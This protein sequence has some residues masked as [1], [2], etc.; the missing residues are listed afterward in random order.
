MCYDELSLNHFTTN[1]VNLHL[2]SAGWLQFRSG[3]YAPVVVQS[4]SSY[5][6][7]KANQGRAPTHREPAALDR[8][9]PGRAGRC[10]Y[11]CI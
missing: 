5:L 10:R 8:A 3:A 2:K 9:A 11:G 7:E 4:T 6:V 1:H